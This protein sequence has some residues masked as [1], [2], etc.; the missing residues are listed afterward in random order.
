MALNLKTIQQFC[1]FQDGEIVQKN[2]SNKKEYVVYTPLDE[3]ELIVNEGPN[4]NDNNM[5]DDDDND[6]Q[7]DDD[8]DMQDDDDNDTQD[9]DDIQLNNEIENLQLDTEVDDLPCDNEDQFWDIIELSKFDPLTG[10]VRQK[11]GF[12]RVKFSQIYKNVSNRLKH[13]IVDLIPAAE[14]E[15]VLSHYVW[16]GREYFFTA[17]NDTMFV[18]IDHADG[19]CFGYNW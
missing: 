13:V 9:D 8:N 17:C 5:Q 6:T 15:R 1:L 12:D 19:M 11:F 4:D 18:I 3:D 2:E 7:D 14:M 10:K 16:Q